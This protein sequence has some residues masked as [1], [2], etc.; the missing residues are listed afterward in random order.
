M[1]K[2]KNKTL[3]DFFKNIGSALG[4]ILAS[5]TE[6]DNDVELPAELSGDPLV[7]F[8]DFQSSQATTQSVTK[9]K[10]RTTQPRTRTVQQK[11]RA[12][13][14]IDKDELDR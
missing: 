8:N 3:I 11:A 12:T 1:E 10:A 14:N 2:L 9:T 5:D 6:I 7:A 4:K 13:Q